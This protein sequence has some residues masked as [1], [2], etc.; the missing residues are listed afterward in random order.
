MSSNFRFVKTCN[1][2][3]IAMV[4]LTTQEEASGRTKVPF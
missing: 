3:P 4:I 2:E 1:I